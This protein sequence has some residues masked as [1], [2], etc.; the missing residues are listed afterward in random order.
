MHRC[1]ASRGRLFVV[2]CAVD[3]LNRLVVK[4]L[5]TSALVLAVMIGAVAAAWI[6][7]AG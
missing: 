7:L 5:V 2:Q 1:I 4:H 3:G 6:N